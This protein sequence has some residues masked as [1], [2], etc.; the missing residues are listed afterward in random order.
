MFA[1]RWRMWCLQGCFT[2]CRC[3]KLANA[4]EHSSVGMCCY[5]FPTASCLVHIP[6]SAGEGKLNFITVS[7][8]SFFFP[9]YSRIHFIWYMLSASIQS[10]CRKHWQLVHRIRWSVR[11][12]TEKKKNKQEKKKKKKWH[13]KKIIHTKL[14]IV[15]NR[16]NDVNCHKIGTVSDSYCISVLLE[17]TNIFQIIIQIRASNTITKHWRLVSPNNAN[18]ISTQSQRNVKFISRAYGHQ[19]ESVQMIK[20]WEKRKGS[21]VCT[22]IQI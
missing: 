10:T 7:S 1:V 12:E 9:S 2:M 22:K 3:F 20:R 6:L 13:Q 8:S 14:V 16:T 11:Q 17:S 18:G 15:C 5:W 21:K 19:T 4:N